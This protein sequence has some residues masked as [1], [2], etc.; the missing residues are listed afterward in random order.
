V[1]FH[2]PSEKLADSFGL[3]VPAT[4]IATHVFEAGLCGNDYNNRA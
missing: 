4:D 1:E 2:L 3:T